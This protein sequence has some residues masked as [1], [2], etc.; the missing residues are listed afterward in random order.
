MP[1]RF[2]AELPEEAMTVRDL[3]GVG[4]HDLRP[5]AAAP[6]AGR[7]DAPSPPGRGPP[8][9]RL[10]TAADLGRRRG[11]RRRPGRRAP[12]TST[13]SVRGSPCSTPN[14]ASGG[15]SP[16]RAPGRIARAASPSPSDPNGPSSSPSPRSG[17]RPW[18]R[19]TG[20]RPRPRRCCPECSRLDRRATHPGRC[21]HVAAGR[22]Y[23]SCGHAPAGPGRSRAGP[24][25]GGRRSPSWAVPTGSRSISARTGGTSRTATCACSARP[26]RSG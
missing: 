11:T 4:Y 14:T 3:S 21:V 18:Q 13:P 12:P 2:L 10:T 22:E 7:P 1:S 20:R 23:R 9:F 17:R 15:S 26:C 24:G 25:L 16:S 5:P 8:S 6:A 19:R